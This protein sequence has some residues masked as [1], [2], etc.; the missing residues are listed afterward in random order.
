MS[1]NEENLAIALELQ[2]QHGAQGPRYIAEQLGAVAL[3]GDAAGISR[4][5]RIAACFEGPV[6]AS[7]Q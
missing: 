6:R 1:E 4:W 5:Q 7:V 2:R 3:R